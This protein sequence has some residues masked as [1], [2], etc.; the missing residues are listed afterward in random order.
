MFKNSTNPYRYGFNGKEKLDE[1]HGNSGD[2]YDYGAR[3]FDA[4]LGRFMSVDPLT[5]SYPWYTPYQFAGDNPIKY[6]DIDG[7]EQGQIVA[8]FGLSINFKVLSAKSLK[9]VANNL[10]ATASITY[11]QDINPSSQVQ[12]VGN[13]SY[14]GSQF[15]NAGVSGSGQVAIQNNNSSPDPSAYGNQL[16]VSGNIN[17]ADG[18]A[19]PSITIQ[20]TP[21][22]LFADEITQT[23]VST[24][25]TLNSANGS[26]TLASPIVGA[27]PVP[28]PA[29][30]NI[31]DNSNNPNYSFTAPSEPK[32]TVVPMQVGVSM[33]DDPKNA[34]NSFLQDVANDKA[35]SGAPVAN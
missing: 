10:K 6:I 19:T 4:R 1:L 29:T 31:P 23:G 35:N 32:S 2:T 24:Q 20:G 9:D 22:T 34:T 30:L 7:M 12:V 3:M 17:I 13:V 21:A 5:K 28:P 18:K 33:M 27:A 8:G 16:A 11:T 25:T 26:T 15:G 14:T